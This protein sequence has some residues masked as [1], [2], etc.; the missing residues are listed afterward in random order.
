M[1][2]K[3]HEMRNRWSMP[4]IRGLA[5]LALLALSLLALGL[6]TGASSTFAAAPTGLPATQ[7]QQQVPGTGQAQATT[8]LGQPGT[9]LENLLNEDGTLN[10]KSGFSGSV[11][12]IG[13]RM[14]TGPNGQPRFVQ[15]DIHQDSAKTLPAGAP[16]APGDENWDDRFNFPGLTGPIGAIAISGS[17]VYVGGYFRQA[18]GVAANNIAK[19][20]GTSWSALGSG[21]NNGVNG[22][23]YA[24]AMSGTD[25][26]VGGLF[27]QAGGVAANCIA[28]WNGNGWAA[29]GSGASNGVDDLVY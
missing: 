6:R 19:W 1:L 12:P 28:K 15:A 21:A 13:W 14:E 18:G 7:Y 8:G 5:V 4:R 17:D 22:S 16:L 20:N 23:V 29:L 25:L 9:P 11:D 24:I 27:T 26:Y 2:P 10:L 3:Q